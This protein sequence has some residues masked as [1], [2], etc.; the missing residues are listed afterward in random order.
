MEIKDQEKSI[1]VTKIKAT[2][3]N[4]G[5]IPREDLIWIINVLEE[6]YPLSTSASSTSSVVGDAS[7]GR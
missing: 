3:E 1:K 7:A 4:I 2:F 5:W 6:C